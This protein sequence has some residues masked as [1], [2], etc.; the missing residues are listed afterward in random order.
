MPM[1]CGHG[2]HNGGIRLHPRSDHCPAHGTGGKTDTRIAAY[3][4]HLPNVRQGIDIQD[5]LLFSKLY[6]SLD[7]RPIPF[8]TLQV[9]ISL[10]HKGR[11]V[12]VMHG[13]A[14]MRTPVACCLVPLSQECRDH[15]CSIRLL[16]ALWQRELKPK[17][18]FTSWLCGCRRMTKLLRRGLKR[19]WRSC[20]P[21]S[22]RVRVSP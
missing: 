16:R 20:M 3:P 22:K 15:P 19:P 21:I 12:V 5:A 13:N 14:F 9:K 17:F 18:L 10:T 2:I 4:F 1:S 6:G 8:D 7:G 11:E